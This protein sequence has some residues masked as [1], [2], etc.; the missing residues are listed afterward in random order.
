MSLC[1]DRRGDLIEQ[2]AAG[3]GRIMLRYIL[4]LSELATDLHSE[5]KSRTQG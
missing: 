5:I 2:V 3:E 1:S 4:P